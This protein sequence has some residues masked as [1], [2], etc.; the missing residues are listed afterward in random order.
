MHEDY[1]AWLLILREVRCAYGLNEPLL[2]YRLRRR[3]KSGSRLRSGR[4]IFRSYR[5]A[6]YSPLA[7]A[8]LTLGYL[9]H[10]LLKRRRIF[11]SRR[12]KG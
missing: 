10:S 1:S 4:L 6:G 3:S 7:A 8:G 2:R 9:P 5:Y 11:R 12:R